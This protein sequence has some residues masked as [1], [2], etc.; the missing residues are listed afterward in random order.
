MFLAKSSGRRDQ[1]VAPPIVAASRPFCLGSIACHSPV[2]GRSDDLIQAPSFVYHFDLHWTLL[3][4]LLPSTST[5][6]TRGPGQ[7]SLPPRGQLL[8][9]PLN[10]VFCNHLLPSGVPLLL[11]H[12][13]FLAH[14]V[15]LLDAGERQVP[16]VVIHK[17]QEAL[18]K[19]LDV[20]GLTPSD[21]RLSQRKSSKYA[22][23]AIYSESAKKFQIC[24]E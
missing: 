9:G 7:P 22:E 10:A 20:L 11:S 2:H 21:L 17:G 14:N 16:E 1:W 19:K 12:T 5:S 18:V 3:A 8:T 13:G 15:S 4:L 24:S 6:I 23:Y